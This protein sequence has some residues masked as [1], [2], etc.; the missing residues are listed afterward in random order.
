MVEIKVNDRIYQVEVA[1]TEE[2]KERGLQNVTELP[3]NQGM[4]FCY[5]EPEDV[6]FWMD[7][8]LIPLDIIFIDDDYEISKVVEGQPNDKTPIGGKQIIYVLEVN[9]GSGVQPGD[10]MDLSALDEEIDE[11]YEEDEGI[12]EGTS[13]GVNPK[14]HVLSENGETQ[15]ELNGGER[16]FS[17]IH[18]RKLISLAKK[19]S[20]SKKDGDY[21]KL[22]KK[23]FEYIDKQNTQKQEYTQV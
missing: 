2:E 15:M 6:S 17:R 4:I 14:M 16:I 11:E 20:K 21:K 18:T 1:R 19:A 23:V 13:E 8:T 22:G 7:Q 12:S 10:V 5:D 3:E 9:A